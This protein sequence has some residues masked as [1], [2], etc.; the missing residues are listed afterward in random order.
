MKILLIEWASF[1]N[2]DIK[3]AF[4]AEG[5]TFSCFPFSNRDGRKDTEIAKEL[6]SVLRRDTPDVVY[7]FNYFPVISQVC[8]TQD[9]K[10][11]SWIYDS[12][13]VML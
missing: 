5:H 7:S 8:K 9:I 13:Y 1:G 11:I 2:E 12:P 6:S 3:E 10:Y 4:T